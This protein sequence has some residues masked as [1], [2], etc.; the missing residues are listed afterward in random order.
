MR[1][2]P[3]YQFKT[4][5]DELQC[6]ALSTLEQREPLRGAKSGKAKQAKAPEEPDE[7]VV[8]RCSLPVRLVSAEALSQMPRYR[9]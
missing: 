3:Y 5:L 6:D 4:G 2:Q 7:F 9:A 1:W 8:E